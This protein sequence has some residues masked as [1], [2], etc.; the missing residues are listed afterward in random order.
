MGR[1]LGD[2][3]ILVRLT[4]VWEI[5]PCLGRM[6]HPRVPCTYLDVL[7]QNSN[8]SNERAMTDDPITVVAAAIQKDGKT[9]TLPAPARHHDII[10]YMIS[11]G[12]KPPCSGEQGFIFSTGEFADREESRKVAVAANQLLP[13]AV[14]SPDLFS[15]DVW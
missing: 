1:Y 13:R 10:R 3:G 12:V 2:E 7:D 11:Q 8:L 6:F 4:L 15:E 9:W 5:L 14:N